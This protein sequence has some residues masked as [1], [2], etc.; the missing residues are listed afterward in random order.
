ML[1]IV[2]W[3]LVAVVAWCYV[4]Y[5]LFMIA[6]ARLRPRPVRLAAAARPPAVT[7]IVAVRNERAHLAR[8]VANILEQEYPADRLG[9]VVA[10][11][12]STDG[13]E[14]I[15][16]QLARADARIR[17]VVS[18]ANE[19]KS[20]AL[21]AAIAAATAEIVVFADAR[22]LFAPD[23]VRQLV[24]PFA[25][26][27]IGAVTG[28]LIVKKSELA[29]VEGVRLYWGMETRLR[30]AESRSGSVVG[31]TGAI[32]AVRRA[33]FPP[34]P[35]NLILD[36]VYVPLC[37]AM[38]GHRV[39][40]AGEA[41]AYD[42]PAGDQRAEYA[43]KR[44]TMVGNLQLL[45]VLP[46]LLSPA[47]NPLFLRYVSHKLL[48]LLAPFCFI[49]MLATSA[50][51]A[52]PLYRAFFFAQLTAYLLG[53]LGLFVSTPVLSI[54]A[55]FVLVHAAV[56]AAVWRWRDDASKVWLPGSR[57]A[58]AEHALPIDVT[59]PAPE[60][61]VAISPRIPTNA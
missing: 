21:N 59:A 37:I 13:S 45:R 9:V 18:A 56:L 4:G 1:E 33:L 17:L 28:R 60:T 52:A 22:Q 36:D 54:P 6:L 32:Y 44:R 24:Q 51:L 11:N 16:S 8:R 29:S 20:G 7:V 12:G 40:M 19:G 53:I 30:D 14:E 34:V 38:A 46:G 48:R 47:G 23:A 26:A 2:F 27:A 25:D 50:M 31:A 39:V 55:A 5:P 35:V 3:L 10:C 41:V 42:V 57:H 43:R 58:Y 61:L 15:A 49:A